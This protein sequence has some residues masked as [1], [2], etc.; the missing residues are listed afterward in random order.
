[1]TPTEPGCQVTA[2]VA[3]ICR[4]IATPA[5]NPRVTVWQ[6]GHATLVIASIA[7]D[8]PPTAS[9]TLAADLPL[10]DRLSARWGHPAA[11]AAGR[12]G[13]S[14]ATTANIPASSLPA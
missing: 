14:S 4:T 9:K 7:S 1:M 10:I 12:Y 11:P 5:S 13:P 2:V 3:A 6:Q 8:A